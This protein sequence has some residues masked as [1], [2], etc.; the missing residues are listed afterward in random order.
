MEER[1]FN[2]DSLVSINFEGLSNVA[3][4]LMDVFFGEN[5]AF[6]L[7]KN[8]KKLALETYNK[9]VLESNLHDFVKA[10]CISNGEK[11][12]KEFSNQCDIAYLATQ[13]LSDDAHPEKLDEGWI[14][15]FKDKAG[16]IYSDDLK[17]LWARVLSGECEN[18]GSIPLLLLDILCKMDVESAKDFSALSRVSVKIGDSCAP[19]IIQDKLDDYKKWGI[20]FDSLVNMRAIGLIEMDFGFATGYT[21]TST[22]L[23]NKITYFENEYCFSHNMS[24]FVGNVIYTKCGK[25]LCNVL[26]VEEIEGFWSGYCLPLFRSHDKEK[27]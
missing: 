3:S 17:L 6:A 14:A 20:S 5:S 18:A 7:K 8:Q 26:E 15:S 19:I 11:T 1:N 10:A 12:L 16:R 4:K 9:S 2:M 21:V 23:P 24:T 13:M 25:E 27:R 22:E